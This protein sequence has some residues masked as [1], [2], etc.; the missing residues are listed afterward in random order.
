MKKH[1]TALVLSLA[2]AAPAAAQSVG[3]EPAE[4]APRALQS[5]AGQLKPVEGRVEMMDDLE[6]IIRI[7]G[8]TYGMRGDTIGRHSVAEGNMVRAELKQYPDGIYA[9]KLVRLDDN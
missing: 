2:L 1:V 9:T 3:S 7:G 4:A 8:T 5:A 6:H